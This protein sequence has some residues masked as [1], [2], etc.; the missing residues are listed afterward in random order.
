MIVYYYYY[1]YYYYYLISGTHDEDEEFII[2][3][4]ANVLSIAATYYYNN[5]V[6]K[7]P[8]HDSSLRGCDYVNEI[9]NGHP[10][11][12]RENLRMD[13]N[14][15]LKLCHIL[16]DE[17]LLRSTRHVKVEEQVA[18]FLLTVGHNER[19][20]VIQERF[21]HSGETISRH[22]NNVLNAFVALI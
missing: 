18:M 20:R 17:G 1:Y 3:I 4:A 16:S 11:R 7:T 19:N 9:L 15:F 6:L 5:F 10:R 13:K 14:V 12:C 2:I 22:F 8:C 21:Q